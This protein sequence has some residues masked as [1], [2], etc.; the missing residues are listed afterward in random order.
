MTL[1]TLI[2]EEYDDGSYKWIFIPLW[3]RLLNISEHWK[4]IV[5]DGEIAGIDL[6]NPREEYVYRKPPFVYQRTPPKNRSEA[7]KLMEKAGV[8]GYDAMKFMIQ[9][10]EMCVNDSYIVD[11]TDEDDY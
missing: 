11:A 1:Y 6:F 10:V 4:E 3:D 7:L 8:R 2:Y 5:G 9:C